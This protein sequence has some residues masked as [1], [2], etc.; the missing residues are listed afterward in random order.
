[1]TA[2]YSFLARKNRDKD[3][4][5]SKLDYNLS[6]KNVFAGSF[7]WNRDTVDRPDEG[8]GYNP[9]PPVKNDDSRKFLAVS[10]RSTPTATLTNEL[11]GGFYLAPATFSSSEKL[12][13]YIIGGTNFSSPVAGFQPQGRNTRTYSLQ[14]NASWVHG[15]HTI[16]FGYQYQAVRVKGYE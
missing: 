9:I 4:V 15:R 2:G 8:A 13:A 5:T 6:T 14:D 3:N 11:R 1:N 12:P 10:W 7:R 16:Q